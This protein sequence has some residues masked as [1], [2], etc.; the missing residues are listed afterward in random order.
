MRFLV[1]MAVVISSTSCPTVAE[2]EEGRWWPV[3]SL[4]HAIVRTTSLERFPTP[5]GAHHMLVQSV[6]GL[7][8]KAVN[9]DAAMSWSG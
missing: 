1:G 6:A 9:A 3:Q 5:H 7:A 4:P 2:A 8:A